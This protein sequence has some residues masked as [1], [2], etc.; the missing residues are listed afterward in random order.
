MAKYIDLKSDFGFKFCMQDETI[1]KSFLNAILDGDCEKITSV[2]F[3]NVESPRYTREG[4]GVIFDLLCTTETGDHILIEMQNSTQ[5]F[6]K[7]RSRFYVYNASWG[8][9]LWADPTWGW[10]RCRPARVN[11]I[12]IQEKN[13]GTECENILYLCPTS[14]LIRKI[15]RPEIYGFIFSKT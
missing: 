8:F 9:S 3:E 4:R 1:M 2:K 5:R 7:T 14:S 10:T 11:V 6:F 12:W 13:F 15:S